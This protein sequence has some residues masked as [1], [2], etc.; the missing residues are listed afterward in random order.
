MANATKAKEQ[1]TEAGEMLAEA[2]DPTVREVRL[3]VEMWA[4]IERMAARGGVTASVWIERQ[5]RHLT[6]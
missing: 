3:P 2:E 6:R 5:L 1:N 4:Q